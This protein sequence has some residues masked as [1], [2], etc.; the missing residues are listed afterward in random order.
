MRTLSAWGRVLLASSTFAAAVVALAT[1]T[2]PAAASTVTYATPAAPSSHNPF[3]VK[4]GSTYYE[5][6]SGF[7]FGF[8]PILE[9]TDLRTWSW[10]SA[11]SALTPA[12]PT[13]TWTDRSD[14]YKFTSPSVVKAQNQFVLYYTAPH[15]GDADH[16]AGQRC[17][18]YAT[19]TSPR[20]PWT[21]GA[22]PLICP[23]G[24]VN[25]SDPSPAAVGAQQVVFVE[26]GSSPGVY[27]QRFEA[28]GITKAS[29]FPTPIKVMDPPSSNAWKDGKVER[30]GIFIVL[31]Q[32]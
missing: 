16:P 7:V 27:A 22:T 29:A 3:V 31:G 25:A 30:P 23:G 21:E 17:V 4:D 20:G 24:G 15:K 9:S 6:V 2:E 11:Q 26:D 32:Q 12:G 5:F 10:P 19:A 18:G 28:D 14:P 13:G 1:T 8:V